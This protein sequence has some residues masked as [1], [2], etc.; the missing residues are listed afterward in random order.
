MTNYE[1]QAELDDATCL[2]LGRFVM[3]FSGLIHS[4]ENATEALS[5]LVTTEDKIN[6]KASISKFTAGVMLDKFSS[7]FT[8]YW[9]SALAKNDHEI[10]DGVKRELKALIDQ[11]NRLMHDVWV[12]KMV[13][14]TENIP[15]HKARHRTIIQN[16][17]LSYE[18]IDYSPEVVEK[19]I[20][21]TK[22]LTLVVNRMYRYSRPGM[23]GPEL[24]PRIK[25]SAGKVNTQ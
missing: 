13:G 4:L 19:L 3:F 20:S 9:G 1:T 18:T 23:V 15:Q 8:S 24:H 10:L 21:D 6:F 25:I 14:G 17:N 16:T 11:R 5:N 7:T 2:S 22:R 12:N